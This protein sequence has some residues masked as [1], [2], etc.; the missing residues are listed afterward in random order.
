L[1]A[2]VQVGDEELDKVLVG[3][4]KAGDEAERDV[5]G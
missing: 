2:A 1:L 4:D 5:A 3:E